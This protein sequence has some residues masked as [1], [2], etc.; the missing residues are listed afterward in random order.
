MI[1]VETEVKFWS[2]FFWKVQGGSTRKALVSDLPTG[3]SADHV[4]QRGVWGN[5][6][7]ILELWEEN[8]VLLCG[9]FCDLNLIKEPIKKSENLRD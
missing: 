1:K 9:Q 6:Y 4:D 5:G 2:M 8:W 3:G 7:F